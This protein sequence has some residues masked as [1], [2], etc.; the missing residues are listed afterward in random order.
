MYKQFEKFRMIVFLAFITILCC[1]HKDKNV[2]VNE[3]FA[4][5]KYLEKSVSPL[6][7]INK[8]DTLII[9]F[10]GTECGEWG[11]RQETIYL[12][13]QDDNK[14]TARILVDEV[15][16]DDIVERNGVGILNPEKRKII[17]DYTKVLDEKDEKLFSDFLQRLMELNLKPH[18]AGNFGSY[19]VVMNTDNSFYLSYWNSGNVMNTNYQRL[20]NEVFGEF[21]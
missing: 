2:S 7:N 18:V 17:V 6:E 8:R 1:S 3:D 15:P 10:E 5:M 21:K 4:T 9:K 12:L 19:Y 16:C 14:I 11:G 13:R 20:I